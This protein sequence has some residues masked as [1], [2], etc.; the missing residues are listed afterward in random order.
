[1]SSQ[2]WSCC[3]HLAQFCK[4]KNENVSA[5]K[6]YLQQVILKKNLIKIFRLPSYWTW[7]VCCNIFNNIRQCRRLSAK[8]INFCHCCMFEYAQVNMHVYMYIKRS[9]QIVL[10][11]SHLKHFNSHLTTW[12]WRL[13]KLQ[14]SI[15]CPSYSMK[16]F[17]MCNVY[18]HFA[19]YIFLKETYMLT[20]IQ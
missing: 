2:C 8:L 15:P 6:M 4:I 16:I 7:Y 13:E 1:M 10:H 17:S 14:R 9:V 19:D 12:I 18:H 11:L 3:S 20:N 5:M